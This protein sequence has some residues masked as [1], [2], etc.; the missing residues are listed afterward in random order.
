MPTA[1]SSPDVPRYQ[2]EIPFPAYTYVPGRA[3]HPASADGHLIGRDEPA[4]AAITGVAPSNDLAWLRGV[5]LF[6]HGYYWEAHEVWE[7]TWKAC[8]KRGLIADFIKALIKLAACGVKVREGRP[9]GI[10]R[11]AAAAR[12]LLMFVAESESTRTEVL[13]LSLTDMIESCEAAAHVRVNAADADAQPMRVFSFI[14]R[15]AV[16][17]RD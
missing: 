10:R 15:P 3:P 17:P 16:P 7:G 11:H 9:N 4:G 1:P 8:G 13:G 5:D 2:P 14:L 12:E 6:N